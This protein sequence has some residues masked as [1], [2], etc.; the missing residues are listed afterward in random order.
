[1]P[2]RKLFLMLVNCNI[3][4]TPTLKTNQNLITSPK[5]CQ[6]KDL[7]FNLSHMY[8]TTRTYMH[9]DAQRSTAVFVLPTCCVRDPLQQ[10]PYQ[11]ERHCLADTSN[12]P[13]NF[14]NRDENIRVLRRPALHTAPLGLLYKMSDSQFGLSQGRNEQKW[15]KLLANTLH[16][17]A[18]FLIHAFIVSCRLV[19]PL[20]CLPY[21]YFFP[22][23]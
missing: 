12:A 19:A 6:S 15:L 8:E 10:L 13:L 17:S 3:N 20:S 4:I 21:I 23:T 7:K 14:K 11:N 18:T 9:I 22:I 16:V 2:N 5:C 1:M